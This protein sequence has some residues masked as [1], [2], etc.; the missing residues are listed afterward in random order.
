MTD[1]LDQITKELEFLTSLKVV[2]DS[3]K[4]GDVAILEYSDPSYMTKCVIVKHSKVHK[5]FDSSNNIIFRV[6][7]INFLWDNDL[8]DYEIKNTGISRFFTQ[9]ES[10]YDLINFIYGTGYIP[11]HED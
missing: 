2:V 11:R 8:N 4:G 6:H 9:E 5:D 10:I 1:N 7:V 3:S